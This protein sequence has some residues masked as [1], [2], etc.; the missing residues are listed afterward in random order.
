MPGVGKSTVGVLLA[1]RLGWTF[2]DTDICIQAGEGRSLQ[3]IIDQR[4]LE[5]FCRIEQDYILCLDNRA[6]VIATGGS[7][8]YSPAAMAHLKAGGVIVYLDLPLDRLAARIGDTHARGVVMPAG[9]TLDQL[10]HRRQPLYRKYADHTIATA[11]LAHEQVVGEIV[12]RI[13]QAPSAAP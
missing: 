6:S 3:E 1:K 11:G 13:K 9:A 2:V 5:A 10:Y 8:V 7:V 4:G 12:A